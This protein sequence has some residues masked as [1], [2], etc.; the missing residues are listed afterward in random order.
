MKPNHLIYYIVLFNFFMA[1]S[2][3]NAQQSGLAWL[4]AIGSDGRESSPGFAVDSSGKLF[5]PVT[6]NQAMGLPGTTDTLLP[7]G[8]Y[9]LALLHLTVGG[10]L[11]K[12]WHF[13]NKGVVNIT[14]ISVENGSVYLSGSHQDTL[15]LM[16]NAQAGDSVIGVSPEGVT[17]FMM[18]LNDEGDVV[19]YTSF[20]VDAI[21]S[22]FNT[23]SLANNYVFTT[24]QFI[25]DTTAPKTNFIYQ[26]QGNHFTTF[27]ANQTLHLQEAVWFDNKPLIAGSYADTLNIDESSY[28]S[29][30]TRSGFVAIIDSNATQ[31]VSFDSYLGAAVTALATIDSLIYVAIDFQDSLFVNDNFIAA[32]LGAVD[33]MVFLL[34][35]NLTV[36]DHFQLG[37]VLNERANKIVVSDQS[38]NLFANVGSP[39]TSLTKNGQIMDSIQPDNIKGNACL[40]EI[41]DTFNADFKWITSQDWSNKINGLHQINQ[42]EYLISGLFADSMLINSS[43]Y[44][45]V[46]HQDVFMMRISDICLGRLKQT[47]IQVNFCEGD[48]VY[49]HGFTLTDK[50]QL[51]KSEYPD[52]GVYVSEPLKLWYG[53]REKSCGCLMADTLEFAFSEPEVNNTYASKYSTYT[54]LDGTEF[55]TMSWCGNC[56][57]QQQ[58]FT[59]NIQ[60]NPFSTQP[61]LTVSLSIP[62]TIR[63]EIIDQ[64]GTV[65]YDEPE[66][67]FQSGTHQFILPT[68]AFSKGNYL[69]RI[70]YMAD[71]EQSIEIVKL[72]KN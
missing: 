32:S 48:S 31:F 22:V 4:K 50:N 37:G 64:K 29:S 67:S 5:L 18:I 9:D 68:T 12:Y 35:R 55:I 71:G 47:A 59:Y 39:L 3:A 38:I 61:Q 27:D 56:E 62:G 72:I 51:V 28:V 24:G 69:L 46:G 6:F 23:I 44:H 45:A 10:E 26:K 36:L 57:K 19:A 66:R 42:T 13:G 49:I 54:L 41:D 33:V 30:Y 43:F 1:F 20:P 58:K 60:P 2:S 11:E 8:G 16:K 52:D 40:V 63:Y 14:D 65:L 70:N 17:G 7:M 53:L 25:A 34:D 21:W 15:R